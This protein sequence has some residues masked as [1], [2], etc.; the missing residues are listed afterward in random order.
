MQG[1]VITKLAS[2]SSDST[3]SCS[4]TP[5]VSRKTIRSQGTWNSLEWEKKGRLFVGPSY[6]P[7]G[8]DFIQWDITTSLNLP[9]K[10]SQL[11]W[12]NQGFPCRDLGF[13]L[14]PKPLQVHLGHPWALW[15]VV[16]TTTADAM[17]L[18]PKSGLHSG[19]LGQM[20]VLGDEVTGRK[21]LGFFVDQAAKDWGVGEAEQIRRNIN[22]AWN[23]C[24]HRWTPTRCTYIWTVGDI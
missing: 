14:K 8:Q 5:E 2:T 6:P 18:L 12:G 23:R 17:R 19:E 22:W 21:Q 4:F 24:T 15:A 9:V 10:V 16:A 3:A 7:C 20:A 13:P 11:L 1:V